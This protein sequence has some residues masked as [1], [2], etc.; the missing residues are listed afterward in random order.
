MIEN[1]TD[2]TD[3]FPL[4]SDEKIIDVA[5]G[6]KEMA[7]VTNQ[8]RVLARGYMFFRIF[9]YEVRRNEYNNEDYTFEIDLPDGHKAENLWMCRKNKTLFVTAASQDGSTK[10][11]FRATEC[12]DSDYFEQT[13][14]FVAL[15]VP[16]GVY[17]VSIVC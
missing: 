3:L 9:D 13:D 2:I 4:K 16:E 10:K 17:F 1:F 14:R 6:S 8:G 11:T 5:H 12:L 15:D 7:A